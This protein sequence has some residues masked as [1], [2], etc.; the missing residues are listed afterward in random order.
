MGGAV[1]I[2]TL[3]TS[4]FVEAVAAALPYLVALTAFMAFLGVIVYLVD[5][6]RKQK[7]IEQSLAQ[8]H[9]MAKIAFEK[10]LQSQTTVGDFQWAKVMEILGEMYGNQRQNP[11][12]VAEKQGSPAAP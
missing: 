11:A 9:D 1:I 12:V 2:V 7:L 5:S 10:Y 4:R 6:T 8:Y 3:I